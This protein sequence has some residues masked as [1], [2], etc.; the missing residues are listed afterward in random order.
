MEVREILEAFV[1]VLVTEDV[2]EFEERRAAPR[3]N[4]FSRSC[5]VFVVPTIRG[6]GLPLAGGGLG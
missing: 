3:V 4:D 2:E 5:W 6:R 1:R